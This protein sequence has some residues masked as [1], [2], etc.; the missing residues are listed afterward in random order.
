MW[1]VPMTPVPTPAGGVA[2]AVV[3]GFEGARQLVRAP[4]EARELAR[5]GFW[6]ARRGARQPDIDTAGGHRMRHQPDVFARADAGEQTGGE[7]GGAK[8][9]RGRPVQLL[10]VRRRQGSA[11]HAT[12]PRMLAGVT[13]QWT[14]RQPDRD[15]TDTAGA[16]EPG[17]PP[18]RRALTKRA[19]A[20]APGR[21]RIAA[22]ETQ[23]QI[24]LERRED[25]CIGARHPGMVGELI[26]R[27]RVLEP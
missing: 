1:C 21:S 24:A 5:E 3:R 20:N 2:R 17:G 19:A 22:V 18:A 12:L 13:P 15:Q 4:H 23:A 8:A 25:A 16:A 27:T 7:D 14:R 6:I 9:D 26:G 10:E 11:H